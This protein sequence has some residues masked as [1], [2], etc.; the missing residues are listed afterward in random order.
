MYGGKDS[1]ENVFNVADQILFCKD[2]HTETNNTQI[3]REV[4]Q[5]I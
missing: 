3:L 4:K 1:F 5:K 2:R